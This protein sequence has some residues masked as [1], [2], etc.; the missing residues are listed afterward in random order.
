M[1]FLITPLA[2]WAV[3]VAVGVPAGCLLARVVLLNGV[4]RTSV[5]RSLASLAPEVSEE[6]AAAIAA[7]VRARMHSINLWSKKQSPGAS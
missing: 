5:T 7:D 3:G 4:L 1:Q 2:A 6:E